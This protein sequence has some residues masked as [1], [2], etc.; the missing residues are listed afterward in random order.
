MEISHKIILYMS[1]VQQ[2]EY[3]YANV[4]MSSTIDHNDTQGWSGIKKSYLN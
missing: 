3:R 1:F 4:L 2:L